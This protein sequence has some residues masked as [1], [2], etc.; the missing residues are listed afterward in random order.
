V[1][2]TGLRPFIDPLP[3]EMQKEFLAAYQREID[4]AYPPH[5]D[6]MRLLAFPRLFIVARRKS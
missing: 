6:G 4:A 3:P 2:A 5:A 1:R